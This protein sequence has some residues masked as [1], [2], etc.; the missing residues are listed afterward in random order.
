MDVSLSEN[1]CVRSSIVHL[2]SP[3]EF[4]YDANTLQVEITWETWTTLMHHEKS[5]RRLNL[6]GAGRHFA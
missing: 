4:K 1:V 3:D 5:G 2:F 6:V